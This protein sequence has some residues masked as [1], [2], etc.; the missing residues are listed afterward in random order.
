MKTA[1]QGSPKAHLGG[2]RC[3]GWSRRIV[4]KL[5]WP[6]RRIATVEL[7]QPYLLAGIEVRDSN[8]HNLQSR[9]GPFES[10]MG[11]SQSKGRVPLLRGLDRSRSRP[12]LRGA[13]GR[14]RV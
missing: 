8:D 11:K 14:S 13:K 5:P 10:S 3:I 7:P 1:W 4:C 9:S 6:V 12:N 2:W